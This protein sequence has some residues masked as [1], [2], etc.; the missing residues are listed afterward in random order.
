MAGAFPSLST[1]NWYWGSGDRNC[2]LYG[3][4]VDCCLSG[5]KKRL[6][7]DI[8][9]KTMRYI[10]ASFKLAVS[11]VG[12]NTAMGTHS[13]VWVFVSIFSP[14][15]LGKL[16]HLCCFNVTETSPGSQLCYKFFP[17]LMVTII[18]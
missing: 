15:F 17:R 11:S 14:S 10:P 13:T 3:P 12:S 6:A 16:C 7:E 2:Y 5:A 1:L 4:V 18:I 8:T 9:S